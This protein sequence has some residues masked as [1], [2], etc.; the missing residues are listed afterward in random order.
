MPESNVAQVEKMLPHQSI[1]A[2]RSYIDHIE[3]EDVRGLVAIMCKFNVKPTLDEVIL[4]ENLQLKWIED[5]IY[6]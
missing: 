1:I 6:F 3:D 5:M 2:L 4:I